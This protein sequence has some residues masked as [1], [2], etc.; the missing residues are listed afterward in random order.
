MAKIMVD[1]VVPKWRIWA[2]RS[3]M[4]VICAIEEIA[5]ARIDAMAWV[6]RLSAWAMRGFK[7]K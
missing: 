3:A 7:V 6:E 1:I 2:V 5:P 4:R